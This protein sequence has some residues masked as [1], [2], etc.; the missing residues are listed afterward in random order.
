L[1]II[2]IRDPFFDIAAPATDVTID[3]YVG[4]DEMEAG[5][6]NVLSAFVRAHPSWDNQDVV[7]A[8]LRTLLGILHRSIAVTKSISDPARI[9]VQH[10]H[11]A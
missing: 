4:T 1:Q 9:H 6:S 10:A 5:H 2:G 8:T 11:K 7:S 3:F